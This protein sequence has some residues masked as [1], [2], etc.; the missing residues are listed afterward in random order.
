MLMKQPQLDVLLNFLIMLSSSAWASSIKLDVLRCLSY[1]VFEC[2][3]LCV[4]KVCNSS[5]PLLIYFILSL[6]I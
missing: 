2:G 3:P 1:V 6:S 4:T 5:S